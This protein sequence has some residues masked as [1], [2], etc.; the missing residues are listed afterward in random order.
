VALKISQF[1]L[2]PS[3]HREHRPLDGTILV[4]RLPVRVASLLF[5]RCKFN[6][7]SLKVV[8]A[9]FAKDHCTTVWQ[10]GKKKF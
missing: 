1:P 10:K 3:M 7:D 8:F 5:G 9:F 4:D 2:H 6:M